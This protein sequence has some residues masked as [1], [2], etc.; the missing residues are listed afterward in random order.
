MVTW[1]SPRPRP[2][3]VCCPAEFQVRLGWPG[4]TYLGALFLNRYENIMIKDP[5]LLSTYYV[6][7]PCCVLYT[8]LSLT[9]HC[10]PQRVGTDTYFTDEDTWRSCPASEQRPGAETKAMCCHVHR[11]SERGDPHTKHTQG[12][13]AEDGRA[14]TKEVEDREGRGEGK[15]DEGRGKRGEEEK[16]GLRRRMGRRGMKGAGE[17]LQIHP[18]PVPF[19][20]VPQGLTSLC[21]LPPTVTP[22]TTT[23]VGPL[24]AIRALTSQ[25]GRPKL[26]GYNL[27]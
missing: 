21:S 12:F 23:P 4:T 18:C 17:M 26:G 24:G 22:L 19:Q 9:L 20:S 6:R 7:L 1:L 3:E 11:A 14:R 13:D 15:W 27:T 2:Y 10:P 5:H 8:L 25:T 16:G